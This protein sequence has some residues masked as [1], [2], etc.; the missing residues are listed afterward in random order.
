MFLLFDI[1]PPGVLYLHR[2]LA[3]KICA[4]LTRLRMGGCKKH[5]HFLG[6]HY[7]SASNEGYSKSDHNFYNLQYSSVTKFFSFSFLQCMPDAIRHVQSKARAASCLFAAGFRQVL[8]REAAYSA[9][10]SFNRF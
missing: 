10:S 2:P 8:L 3:V 4:A 7:N 1:Q 5:G 6:S 9:S